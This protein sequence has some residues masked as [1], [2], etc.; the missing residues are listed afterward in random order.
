MEPRV[1]ES[2]NLVRILF[3]PPANRSLKHAEVRTIQED[4]PDAKVKANLTRTGKWP[5]I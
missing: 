4:E 3:T 5:E 2:S 1:A